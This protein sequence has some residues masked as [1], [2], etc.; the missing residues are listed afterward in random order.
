[1]LNRALK[2]LTSLRLTVVLLCLALLLVFG[3]TLAQ[4]QLGLYQ[5]QSEF[6]RSFFIYWHPAGSH[7]RIPV[8]PG[9]WLLGALLFVNLIAA[10]VKRFELSWKKSGIFLTH[11]GLIMLLAGQF[12]TERF[13]TESLMR[14]KV[15]GTKNYSEDSRHNEL[16]VIDTTSPD[17]DEVTAIPETLL[18]PGAE[19]KP[20]S[21]PFTIRVKEFL[22]NSTPTG[23]MVTNTPVKLNSSRGLGARLPFAPA[24]LATS[25][26]TENVPAALVE[27]TS[28]KGPVGDWIV[29]TWLTKYPELNILKGEVGQMFGDELEQPQSFEFN[30]HTYEMALRPIRY[31]KPY[32][33]TLK[34]FTHEV[35]AGTDVPKNF[36]SLVHLN[37]PTKGDDR[38][39]LIHMNTPLRH[40]GD[41]LFQSGFD[42]NDTVTILQVVHN[43]ASATPY[44]ACSVVAIGLLAQFGMHLFGFARKRLAPAPAVPRPAVKP[45]KTAKLGKAATA[46]ERA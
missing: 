14:I 29:T 37:D 18:T 33:V 46:V 28:D 26:D 23:P 16:A 5:V 21:L 38:D 45:V 13:Q 7:F 31:Y 40:A 8:Y 12:M 25:M 3:G 15:G 20:A 22:P 42:E 39:V 35:Y 10:H 41:T 27:V 9:G 1:M 32:T 6:F 30:G 24:R 44:V 17:K 11:L 4:V 43:P 2:F 19:I 34:Q 36:A